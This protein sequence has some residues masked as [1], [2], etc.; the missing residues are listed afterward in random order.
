MSDEPLV[1]V[2]VVNYRSLET[3]L[4]CLDSL[5]KTDYP[6]FEVIVVDSMTEGVKEALSKL[7]DKRVKLVHFDRDIGAA[8]SHNVGVL[9]SSPE[10]EYIAFLDND[11][12][13]Q[14]DW[15]SR[16]VETI[17]SDP[18]IGAV[19]AKVVSQ[20]NPG[21]MDHTGL[22]VDSVGTWL[23]T[24]GWDHGIFSEPM[25]I[26]TA[27]SAAM[28]T[29]KDAYLEV[30]GFDDTYFIYDDDTDYSWR[31]RLRGYEVVFDPRAVVFH[32]DRLEKRVSFEKLYFGYR[33]RLLNLVK[34][35]EE[36]G[37]AAR[38]MLALYLGYINAALLAL[39]GRGRE[40]MAYC[41]ASL[42]VLRRLRHYIR[43]RRL[44]A[45]LRKVGD[46]ELAKRGFTN[47]GLYATVLMI[48]MLLVRYFRARARRAREEVPGG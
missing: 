17:S 40:A 34:N 36:P 37:M 38:L 42:N 18:R 35:V 44:V 12:V 3:L 16:L 31:L 5:L 28:L 29:R 26:F 30:W 47:K 39:A 10:A 25:V 6:N 8:A 43:M 32:E 19:Q 1:S 13:V 22:G 20:S 24:Y 21:K 14:P 11:T 33:N 9:A 23:T 15:L 48:R 4:R 45:R 46:R 27:S 2:V 41:L 7:D